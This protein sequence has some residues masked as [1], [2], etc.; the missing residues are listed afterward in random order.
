DA[1][2]LIGL[3]LEGERAR[4]R[5]LDQRGVLLRHALQL[6]D[7]L[8]DLLDAALLLVG[9]AGDLADHL[10]HLLRARDDLL[11][12]RAGGLRM[13][14][15]G[16]DLRDA[17]VD[18]RLDLLGGLRAA[19]REAAH[20][21]RHHREAASLLAGTRRLDRGVER[22]D[23]GL[24]GDALDHAEDVG[25]AAHAALDRAGRVD[26]ALHGAGALLRDALGVVRELRGAAA[27]L[28]V[29]LHRARE[30]LHAG[31]RLLEGGG[32]LLRALR[33]VR[34]ALGDL[35]RR[36]G[37]RAG[38]VAR[39]ADDAAQAGVRAAQRAHEEAELA[40]H[41]PAHQRLVGCR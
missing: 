6:H 23:V 26:H 18:Q 11:D 15:A 12:H 37:D 14:A 21:A 41:D 9:G 33:K 20:F 29:L 28:G 24:E 5:L 36:R 38:A 40:L 39:L 3:L 16:G 2:Q 4:R 13:R 10:A 7:R 27:A 19:L 25:H 34:I 32:L 31:S 30:L 8:A 17:I 35:L 22:E 1:R